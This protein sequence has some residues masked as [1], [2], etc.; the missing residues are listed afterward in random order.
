MLLS[1]ALYVNVNRLF[2]DGYTALDMP[3]IHSLHVALEDCLGAPHKCGNPGVESAKSLFFGVEWGEGGS[4]DPV[5][6]LIS[7]VGER[8]PQSPQL[9][10]PQ[11]IRSKWVCSP[12]KCLQP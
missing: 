5:I 4:S 12:K 9:T 6:A 2:T 1:L 11:V 8:N 3:W 10:N 7:E